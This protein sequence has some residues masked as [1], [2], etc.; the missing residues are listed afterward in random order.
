LGFGV[1]IIAEMAMDAK[2]D[3]DLSVLDLTPWISTCVTKVGFLSNR[4]LPSFVHD[5]IKLVS[6]AS[7]NK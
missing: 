7:P 3:A 4:Y 2:L 5:F 1:G 6:A